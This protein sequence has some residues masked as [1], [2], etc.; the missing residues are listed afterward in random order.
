VN[1][2]DVQKAIAQADGEKV[3]ASGRRFGSAHG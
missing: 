2:V 1:A 3:G